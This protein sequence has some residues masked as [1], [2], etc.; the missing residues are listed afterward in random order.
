MHPIKEA[1][2]DQNL[3]P[4]FFKRAYFIEYIK[5]IMNEIL[6]YQEKHPVSDEAPPMSINKDPSPYSLKFILNDRRLSVDVEW[7]KDSRVENIKL[8]KFKNDSSPYDFIHFL[9]NQPSNSTINTEPL[10]G[11]VSKYIGELNLNG[12][13]GELFINC[14]STHIA[15]LKAN[16]AYLKYSPSVD[17]YVLR[18]QIKGLKKVKG[19][20]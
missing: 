12:I 5:I 7:S 19:A 2:Q 17:L 18:E 15:S 8:H 13:L 9:L 16:P 4:S 11:T 10:G 14:L 20:V 1:I 3:K 6:L